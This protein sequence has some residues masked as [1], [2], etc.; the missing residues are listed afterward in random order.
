MP[1][2]GEFFVV[3]SENDV[4]NAQK[5]SQSINQMMKLRDEHSKTVQQTSVPKTRHSLQVSSTDFKQYRNRQAS[6]S[7]TQFTKH[8]KQSSQHTVSCLRGELNKQISMPAF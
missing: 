6:T 2:P 4:Y 7:Q 8:D 5:G 1:K 3:S